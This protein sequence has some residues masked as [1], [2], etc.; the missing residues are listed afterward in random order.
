VTG[1]SFTDTKR[2]ESECGIKMESAHT[3]EISSVF[4]YDMMKAFGGVDEF[5][6]KFI[7]ILRF[8]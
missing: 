6:A 1:V 5:M 8:L 7:S 2:L 3:H 4:M